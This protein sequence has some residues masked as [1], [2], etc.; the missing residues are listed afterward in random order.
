MLK[1]SNNTQDQLYVCRVVAEVKQNR[2]LIEEQ[3]PVLT[4]FE[5]R[6]TRVM[7]VAI[8]LSATSRLQT[9]YVILFTKEIVH[10]KIE[11]CN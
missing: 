9:D 8:L 7:E 11:N 5:I 4:K 10:W 3:T 1:D 6:Y 2:L